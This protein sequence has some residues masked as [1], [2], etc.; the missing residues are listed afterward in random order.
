MTIE[1]EVS[2]LPVGLRVL[3]VPMPHAQSVSTAFFVGIGSRGEDQPTNGL[4]HYLEHMLF[5]G[6][7]RRPDAQAISEAIEG[8]G[9]VLNAYTTRELTC[10]WNTVPFEGAETSIDVTADMLQHSL[11]AAEEIDRERTV[12]QQEIRRAHDN[13]G[14]WA[15]ELGHHALFGDQPIGWA[16]AGSLDTVEGMQRPHFVDHMQRFYRAENSVLAVAGN[17]THERVM[18]LAAGRFDDLPRGAAPPVPSARPGLP[19]ERVLVDARAIEQT[20]LTLSTQ[21]LARRDPDRYAF[22]VLNAVLGRGMSSRLFKEVRERRG[23]AYSVGSHISR[24]LDIGSFTVSAGVT[25]DH[26]EEAL[27]VILSELDRVAAEPVSADELR[28]TIDYLA[29]S[30]R[31]SLET[32]MSLGQRYGNQLLHDGAVEPVDETIAAIRAVTADDVQ[33][34]AR[35][36]LGRRDYALAVV[37]PSASTER[38]TEILAVPAA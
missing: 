18:G 15:G 6:T 31:L 24:F 12:V 30:L 37:G 34:V 2:T 33:R 22:E 28:R 23:L 11:L 13:P 29:G 16:I 7:E 21:A 32:P 9:G 38:L 3:T 17:I 26:Q 36:V 14:Q 19:S 10:Y 8:A 25:R 20:N 4:S 35:R 1:W 27:A 5:K